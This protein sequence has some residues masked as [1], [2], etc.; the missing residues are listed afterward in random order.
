MATEYIKT[1]TKYMNSVEEL[2]KNKIKQYTKIYK[3]N[4]TRASVRNGREN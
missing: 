1:M 2:R 4:A 3:D